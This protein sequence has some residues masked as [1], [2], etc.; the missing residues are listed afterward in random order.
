MK[1]IFFLQH[2]MY[3]KVENEFNTYMKEVDT[4]KFNVTDDN[5][6]KTLELN[7]SGLKMKLKEIEGKRKKLQESVY[8]YLLYLVFYEIV[9]YYRS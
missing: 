9:F 8:I 3:L 4:I 1:N 2:K 7:L 5:E 6:K